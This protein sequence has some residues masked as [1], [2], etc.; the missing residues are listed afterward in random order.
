MCLLALFWVNSGYSEQKTPTVCLNMIVKDESRV[1]ERCL[2]SLKNYIDTWVIVDT[3]STDGTQELIR[4][5]LAEVPGEL[6]ERPWVNFGHNRQ[7][8][9]TLAKDK[10]DYVLFID[11]DEQLAFSPNFIKPVLE[12]DYYFVNFS[13]TDD[14]LLF[15]KVLLINMKKDWRWKGVIHEQLQS[16]T[17][18]T[19]GF[20]EPIRCIRNTSSSARSQDP[21]KYRK[22]AALLEKALITEPDNSRYVFYLAQSYGN[23]GERKLALQNYEK[24][25]K[26]GGWDQEVF[27]S[28]LM[29]AK[30][31]E[32]LGY[33][34]ESII[35]S[36]EKTYEYRPSRAEPLFYLSQIYLKQ[37]NPLTAYALGKLALSIPYPS[38]SGYIEGFVYQYGIPYA[39]GTAA[40]L[41]HKKDEALVFYKQVLAQKK[42]PDQARIAVESRLNALLEPVTNL[43]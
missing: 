23:A 16:D 26:M 30:L 28:L 12:K 20:L 43:Q 1:I 34:I 17:A 22:D 36:Y 3:G 33:P 35:K 19:S 27:W 18:I 37:N 5:T 10:A 31:Q 13:D 42:L 38:D 21:N 14:D 39:L 6:Y 4:K 32:E 24:R 41:L 11:A 15:S 29:T 9:L 25:S 40:Q 8:A 2:N 7:E